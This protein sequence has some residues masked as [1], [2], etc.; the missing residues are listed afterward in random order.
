[1]IDGF[2]I[3]IRTGIFPNLGACFSR[4]VSV[5]STF[6]CFWSSRGTFIRVRIHQA[7]NG[8]FHRIIF[9]IAQWSAFL[10]WKVGRNSNF[11]IFRGIR[12]VWTFRYF[13]PKK[14]KPEC[15]ASSQRCNA[16][17]GNRETIVFCLLLAVTIQWT[18]I[19]HPHLGEQKTHQILIWGAEISAGFMFIKRFGVRLLESN[20][21]AATRETTVT[22]AML[23][24]RPSAFEAVLPTLQVV[25]R[26]GKFSE[27]RA[28]FYSE[29]RLSVVKSSARTTEVQGGLEIPLQGTAEMDPKGTRQYSKTINRLS[30]QI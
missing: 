13:L 14:L 4:I 24:P 29:E 18:A 27:Q 15:G 10:A 7:R 9:D 2:R 25:T 28:F 20:W 11:Q 1:M 3:T 5:F 12:I 22:I 21:N 23:L 16:N 19:E 17:K 26:P 8:R 6:S 30:F